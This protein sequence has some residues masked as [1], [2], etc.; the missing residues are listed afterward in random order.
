MKKLTLIIEK[1]GNGLLWGRVKYKKNL[2]VEKANSIV[3]LERKM[4]KLLADF[5]NLESDMI[6]FDIAY[7]LTVL[8]EQ[9]DF[10]NMSGVAKMANINSSLLRQYAAGI[11]F[12]S[13]GKAAEIESVLRNIGRELSRINISARSKKVEQGRSKKTEHA[14]H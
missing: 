13:P 1:T 12:P 7:D 8:F 10:L 3:S 4:R 11:K 6:H 2:L 5:H 9:K 14:I